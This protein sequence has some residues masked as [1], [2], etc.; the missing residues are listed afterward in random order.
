MS[1]LGTGPLYPQEIFLV[2]IYVRSYVDQ[3]VM[4]LGMLCVCYGNVLVKYSLRKNPVHRSE[5]SFNFRQEVSV[6]D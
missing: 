2:L 3:M 1:A 4:E 5:V 6:Y